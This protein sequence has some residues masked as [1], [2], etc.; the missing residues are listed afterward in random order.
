ML[1]ALTFFAYLCNDSDPTNS[2]YL[3]MRRT[4]L[5]ALA[6]C[7]GLAVKAADNHPFTVPTAKQWKA[8]KGTLRL[9]PG[10]NVRTT[11]PALDHAA[12]YLR[13]SLQGSAPATGTIE[14]R[15]SNKK[16]AP[17]A[18]T[19]NI[20]PKGATVTGSTPQGVLW[21]IQT[22]LQLQ[23]QNAE[24][25]C[26]TVSDQPDYK[27]RGFMIDCGRK[28]IPMD[29]LR[30]LVRTMSY[31][32]MNTLQIHL[33]DNGFKKYYH[34]RWEETY[35]AF[36]LESEL[37]PELTA[38]D[39]HY[40]KKE[41][42]EFVLESQRLGVE[43]IPEIDAPAHALAFIHMRPSLG[44]EEFGLDHLDLTN[45]EV[46]PFIDSLWSEYIGGPEPVFAGPRVH[47]GTDEYSNKKQEVVELFRAFTD[48]L[49]KYC[50]SHG[51]Q[52]V[53]WGSL[54]YAKGETPVQVKNVLM[55]LWSCGFA[56]PKEMREAGY[57]LVSIPDGLV[58]IVPAAGYYYDY[59][60][61]QYLYERWTPAHMGCTV[62]PEKDPQVEGG[63]F[64]VWNDVC[65]NGISVG[66]I[67]HRTFPA[68]Q[69]IAQKTWH[70][71]NDTL[72]YAQWNQARRQLG[73]G[74]G[75]NE[76]GHTIHTAAHLAPNQ[77]LSQDELAQIGYDYQIDFDITW[78]Q[79]QPGAVLTES[80]RSKFYLSDPISGMLGY[81]RDGYLFTFNYS[82]RPG[83]TEHIT[84]K[85]TNRETALYVNGRH[86]QTLGYDQRIAHDLKPY[87]VVRTLVFPL[88]RTGQFLS[89]V[90]NFQAAKR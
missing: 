70:A 90:T 51:K 6:L 69:V 63:F 87:N 65:G 71:V 74:P 26:G 80:A 76:L 23:G 45:P 43:I 36:R 38:K 61:D 73:E 58:Y 48:H 41:F 30:N 3:N 27:M 78:G 25:P 68:L 57:Q 17:E 81:S 7:L 16:M 72:G 75:V 83:L 84:L 62:L 19:L 77:T 34:D 89:R 47:I 9:G 22:L 82:G 10:M 64:A 52:P 29:Y 44:S 53:V 24:V 21:G 14:L 8:A 2:F 39:G 13:Q 66:D 59:L 49:I 1:N 11:A 54:T 33:N 55:Q 37:F 20:T 67:H 88:Q 15:L 42:R 12:H 40:T 35:S 86:I 50:E 28:H 4:L 18:Y 85:G 31:Y 79:E 32:K 56:D 46:I 5:L 60:N